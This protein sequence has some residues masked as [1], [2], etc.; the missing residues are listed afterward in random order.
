MSAPLS[1]PPSVPLALA[2]CLN[3]DS[4]AAPQL[5]TKTKEHVLESGSGQ[6]SGVVDYSREDDGRM[7]DNIFTVIH[8]HVVRNQWL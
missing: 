4:T 3:Y 6:D 1:S 8:S 5:I 7:V 2:V